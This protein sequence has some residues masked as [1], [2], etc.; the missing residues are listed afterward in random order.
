MPVP[1]KSLCKLLWV[2]GLTFTQDFKDF[3]TIML[4]QWG[5]QG[6]MQHPLLQL[7]GLARAGDKAKTSW[8]FTPAL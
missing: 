2:P 3:N 8:S 4:A 5:L 1:K 7:Q 6:A